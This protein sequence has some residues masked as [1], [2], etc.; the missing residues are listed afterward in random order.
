MQIGPQSELA[1]QAASLISELTGV[2]RV[3]FCSSGTEAV[4]TAMRVAR[5]ATRRPKI[6]VFAGSYH[7]SFDGVLSAIPL[8]LGSPPGIDHDVVVLEYGAE[9]ALEILSERAD[10]FAA[11]L[12]E[13]VQGRRPEFQPHAFLQKLRVLTRERGIALIFDEVLLG[14]RIHLGGAQA[15]FGV[16]ADIVTYGK[17]AGGGMPIGVISGSAE[18]MDVVDGGAW[19][20]GD[21]STPLVDQIWFAG[22][23]NKNPMTMAAAVA[24]LSHLKASGPELQTTL[25]QRTD[26]FVGELNRFFETTSTQIQVH[27]FGSMLRFRV[28]RQLE[29]F[30]H[31]LIARGVYIW[32]GRS[33][34]VS[35]AHSNADLE[36]VVDA[37]RGATRELEQGGFVA[38]PA[39]RTSYVGARP[40]PE[41]LRVFC[42]P[43]AGGT[44][45]HYRR[46][47]RLLPAHVEL[48]LVQIPGRDDESPEPR[49]FAELTRRVAERL[50]PRCDTPFA[51]LGHSMGALLAFEV[52]RWM[53][54]ESGYCPSGL[55][56][57]GEPAPQLAR[58]AILSEL[59]QHDDR[60]LAAQLGRFGVARAIMEDEGVMRELL[61]RLRADLALCASYS[62]RDEEPL[63]FPITAFAGQA[64]PLAAKAEVMAWAEQT[65]DD[66]SLRVL[67]GDHSFV[68]SQWKAICARL[69][70]DI[71]GPLA[72][73]D[74]IRIGEHDEV[75]DR[76][77]LSRPAA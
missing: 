51:L 29:L 19:K 48:D 47:A 23:F 58:P 18:F 28:P 1:E 35:T 55:F 8:T 64:D 67:P 63:A 7:G 27:H 76:V 25:N 69:R 40:Q 42:F 36:Q 53:R 24:A 49:D 73:E 50:L 44:A 22:T 16:E 12:V 60:A 66:F 57:S 62:Y 6:A 14:F 20:Y 37:V 72:F 30:Y 65:C 34:F 15:W 38:S 26:A 39:R 45:N 54:R 74:P 17:I 11:V 4:M 10:E 32:E 71:E 43:D 33:S 2:S 59:S 31:H 56:V 52:A 5:A 46:W 77:P 70:S 75:D 21:A 3:A 9:S 68:R 61:P 13:P 41:P